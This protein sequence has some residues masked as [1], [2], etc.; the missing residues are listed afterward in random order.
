MTKILIGTVVGI[1][2]GAFAVEILK[3]KSP[4]TFRAIED[5]A[6]KLATSVA[7]A[8]REGEAEVDSIIR[9]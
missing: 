9:A 6:T 1:F 5:Q 2:L 4:K 8:F 3:K 7:D